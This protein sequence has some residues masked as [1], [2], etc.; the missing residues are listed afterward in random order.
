MA[1]IAKC[2]MVVTA[3]LSTLLVGCAAQQPAPAPTPTPEAAP[4][5]TAQMGPAPAAQPVSIASEQS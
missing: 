2:T 4:P 5:T 3:S 1:M